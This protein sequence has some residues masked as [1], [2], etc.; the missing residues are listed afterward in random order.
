MS[1]TVLDRLLLAIRDSKGVPAS[2]RSVASVLLLPAGDVALAE[3]ELPLRGG[4]RLAQA[5]VMQSKLAR[6]GTLMFRARRKAWTSRGSSRTMAG[7]LP[8]GSAYS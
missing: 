4:A 7:R 8:S 2:E 5:A 6:A 1:G 3:P